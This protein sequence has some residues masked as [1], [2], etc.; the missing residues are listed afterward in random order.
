MGIAQKNAHSLGVNERCAFMCSDYLQVV[1]DRYDLLVSNPPYITD[2]AMQELDGT[3]KSYEP[4]L[5]LKG[6]AD[7]LT[8]YREILNAAFGVLKTQGCLVFEIGYDQGRSVSN[9]LEQA[10]FQGIK[11]FQD[12]AGHDRIVKCKKDKIMEKKTWS[13]PSL[14]LRLNHRNAGACIKLQ[15]AAQKFEEIF[16]NDKSLGAKEI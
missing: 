10:G 2:K 6:G 8:P 12:L 13:L 9:L 14:P 5:A 15:D 16:L 11:V 1:T 7:G 4:H 3:V